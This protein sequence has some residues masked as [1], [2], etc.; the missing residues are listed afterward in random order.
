MFC[1]LT[2]Q[3]NSHRNGVITLAPEETKLEAE[4]RTKI[5]EGH[6]ATDRVIQDRK[7]LNLHESFGV[8]VREMDADT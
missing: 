6:E 7:K 1:V 5:D 2:Q 4:T 8:A 3:R